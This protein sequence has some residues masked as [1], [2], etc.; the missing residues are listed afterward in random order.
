MSFLVNLQA[1]K[2]IYTKLIEICERMCQT[3][4]I[5]FQKTPKLSKY[6]IMIE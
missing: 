6:G 4:P 1:R 3:S 2:Q 5:S